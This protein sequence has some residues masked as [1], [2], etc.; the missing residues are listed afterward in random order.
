MEEFRPFIELEYL[1]DFDAFLVAY[2]EVGSRNFEARALRHRLDPEEIERWETGVV[3]AG[4]LEGASDL[5]ARREFMAWDGVAGEVVFPDFGRPFELYGSPSQAAY[6]EKEASPDHLA[7]GNRAYNRWLTHFVEEAGSL[8]A[9]MAPSNRWIDV[10]VVISELET[11]RDAGF[12]GIVLPSFASEQPLF[13][14]DHDPIWSAIEALDLV[15]ACHGPASLTTTAPLRTP[16]APH[17][18]AAYAIMNREFKFFSHNVLSHLIWGGVLQRHPELR[19]VFTEQGSGWTIADLAQ[20]DHTYAD[21]Y[22]RR[23]IRDVLPLQPSDYFRR[24]CYLGSSL[25]S[26][27]EV[28]SRDRIGVD[29]MMIGTD[30]PHHEG[31]LGGGHGTREYLRATFGEAH[32][33]EA[34][35][36]L[37]L[38]E[39]AAAVYR[40]DIEEV[41]TV[42]DQV[43][44][45]PS[46]VLAPPEHDLFPRGDIRRPLDCSGT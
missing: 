7:A 17:P 35:A 41:R 20:M 27:A 9:A 33:P 25:F 28:A 24:Q 31:T 13:H 12:R 3:E 1:D 45:W 14:P 16:G 44:P 4:F 43:G 39:T 36:R 23:D 10:A 46:E 42:A 8:S 40:F 6:L 18:A 5:K 34:E 32:V 19:V 37:M 21:S 15:V 26:R 38:G 22:L 30:Y 2:R 29:R 11:F